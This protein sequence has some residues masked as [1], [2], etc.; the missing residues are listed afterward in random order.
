M[1]CLGLLPQSRRSIWN[2]QSTSQLNWNC[3]NHLKKEEPANSSTVTSFK[4]LGESNSIQ[5]QSGS[6]NQKRVEIVAIETLKRHCTNVSLATESLVASLYILALR[7]YSSKAQ[8]RGSIFA[9]STVAMLRS[10]YPYGIPSL[11]ACQACRML[12]L[13]AQID[14][15]MSRADVSSAKGSRKLVAHKVKTGHNMGHLQRPRSLSNLENRYPKIHGSSGRKAQHIGGLLEGMFYLSLHPLPILKKTHS[16][17]LQ[18]T[19]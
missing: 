10:V 12:I 2:R 14:C 9:K 11:E 5:R 13:Q 3:H 17:N 6:Q 7:P 8:W 19:G 15:W 18:Q 16:S 1:P 4:T